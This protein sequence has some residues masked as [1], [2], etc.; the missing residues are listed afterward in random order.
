MRRI[1]LAVLA[2]SAIVL[3]APSISSALPVLQGDDL[4]TTIAPTEFLSPFGPIDFVGNPPVGGDTIVRRLVDANFPF[5]GVNV[6]PGAPTPGTQVTI[7]I[8]M[9][10]L[11][12]QSTAPVVVSGTPYDV[13]VAL[14]PGLPSVGTMNIRHEWAESGDLRPEGTLDAHFALIHALL[15]LPTVLR[16]LMRHEDI[17]TTMAYYVGEKCRSD[18]RCGLGNS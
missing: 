17:A 3:A 8:Q 10:Q 1:L 16:E 9:L 12:W 5:D 4:L 14:D 13:S 6:F 11:S 18:S 2:L 7:P 15:T